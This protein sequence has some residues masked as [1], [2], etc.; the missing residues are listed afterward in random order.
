MPY[1]LR[2]VALATL[3]AL[4]AL[5]ACWQARSAPTTP[6]PDALAVAQDTI[7]LDTVPVDVLLQD[8]FTIDYVMGRFDPSSHPDFVPVDS[9]Y[10]DRKGM[11]LRR[12][13]YAAFLRMRE[14]AE[15]DGI[16]LQIRSATRN[17]NAQK[18]IWEDK[19][20]GTRRIESGENLAETTPDPTARALKILRYSSMPGSS[21]HHWGTDI[22][23]NNFENDWFT[24][25][26][27]LKLYNWMKANAGTYGF[28]QPYT[29]GRPHGYLEERWHWS[30]MPVSAP[31]TAFARDH[32]RNEMI[33][34]FLGSE[35]AV[36]I[37]IVDTY[38]L[39]INP[40][41]L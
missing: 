7:L 19:W 34:G 13:T 14:H 28:C 24:S 12:D 2:A 26:E 3:L 27:G 8:S 35:T 1:L 36:S 38:M 25:G 39:G 40:D 32:L 17:F 22:D 23:I 15:R 4:M 9:Q 41:C 33:D 20:S 11:Y 5:P 6:A 31:L 16:I 21:R 29:A 18:K 10:A 30:Y 37:D